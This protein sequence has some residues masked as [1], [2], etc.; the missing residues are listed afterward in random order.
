VLVLLGDHQPAA[1]VTGPDARWDVP[2]H[3]IT[4]RG[5]IIAALLD[6][7]FVSGVELRARTNAPW[8]DARSNRFAV[9]RI[10]LGGRHTPAYGSGR[11]SV[12]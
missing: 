5:D 4:S 3:V 7:G 8:V 12:R 10:R 2:V 9:A 11:D 6:E 1:S